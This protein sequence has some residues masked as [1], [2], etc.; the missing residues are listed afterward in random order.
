MERTHIGNFELSP[1]EPPKQGFQGYVYKAFDSV[2]KRYVAIKEPKPRFRGDIPFLEK[3]VEEGQIVANFDHPN[4]C[5]L[6]LA[7]NAD[8]DFGA[9]DAQLPYL[10]MEWIDESVHQKLNYENKLDEKQVLQIGIDVCGALD[11]G[12][13]RVP[14]VI[15]RDIK[16]RNLLMKDGKVKVCDFGL[17]IALLASESLSQTVNLVGTPDYIPPELWDFEDADETSDIYSL[18]ITLYELLNGKP[19]F[20]DVEEDRTNLGTMRFK[21]QKEPVP[22][23]PSI[24]QELNNVIQKA[25]EKNRKDRFQSASEMLE[26]LESILFPNRAHQNRASHDALAKTIQRLEIE[27]AA[28]LMHLDA[29][30]RIRQDI[31]NDP[32]VVDPEQLLTKVGNLGQLPPLDS[33][34]NEEPDTNI[35]DESGSDGQLTDSG[36]DLTLDTGEYHRARSLKLISEEAYDEAGKAIAEA[37]EADPESAEAF[38]LRGVILEGRSDINGAL[39]SYTQAISLN[40]RYLEAFINRGDAYSARAKSAK[41]ENEDVNRAIED[42]TSALDFSLGD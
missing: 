22:L 32:S 33:I 17:A 3:F 15:H 18:G 7:G 4:I 20:S 28:A 21:H 40:G 2:L 41:A 1:D 30:R 23:L 35:D 25:T 24:S 39:D 26:E 42:Y 31:T 36:S 29:I 37:I 34:Q 12:H 16:P 27:E 6:H 38:L 14:K 11:Y 10:V 5:I 9:Q 13:S 8:E 19:P